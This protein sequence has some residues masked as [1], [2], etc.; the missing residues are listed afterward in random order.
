[1]LFGGAKTLDNG[2]PFMICILMLFRRDV[3]MTERAL[4]L[5]SS[6]MNGSL[7]YSSWFLNYCRLSKSVLLIARL[8]NL[9]G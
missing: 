4:L 7:R 8:K 9:I 3:I 6:L 1:M 2:L 5:Y